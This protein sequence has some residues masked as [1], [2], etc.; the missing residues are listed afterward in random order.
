MN[1]ILY[2]QLKK[3]SGN[4]PPFD[5]T[6]T[7]IFIPKGSLSRVE[8]DL[9][10][11]HSYKIAVED[12]IVNPYEGFTLHDNWNSGVAPTDKTMNCE[13][14]QIMGKMIK[15]RAIG[16]ESH[17]VWEGWLPQK[18]IHIIEEL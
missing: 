14:V 11:N 10:L 5:E 7:E 12:Y 15:V 9:K 13:V 4:L 6:T 1:K 16:L 2:N 17:S 3:C 8:D 18:S